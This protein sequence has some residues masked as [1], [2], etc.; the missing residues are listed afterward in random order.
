MLNNPFQVVGSM[1]LIPVL[2]TLISTLLNTNNALGVADPALPE[3]ICVSIGIDD[4]SKL[5][6][7]NTSAQYVDLN[8]DGIKELI[9]VYGGGS[10]GSNYWVFKLDK[11]VKW[12]GIGRWCG[13]EDGIFKVKKTKHNGYLDIWSCGYSGFF[14][15]KKYIGRRQ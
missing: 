13:C 14:N 3:E 12:I 15:G 7:E 6:E 8:Q 5:T 1:K 2:T 10:C 9:F 11:R 4:C